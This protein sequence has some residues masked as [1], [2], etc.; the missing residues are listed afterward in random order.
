MQAIAVGAVVAYSLVMT[1]LI[2]SWPTA[3]WATGSAPR[4][5]AIGLDLS[6]HGEAAYTFTRHFPRPPGPMAP[7][8]GQGAPGTGGRGE[9]RADRTRADR[10]R[11]Q[12]R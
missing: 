4:E 12:A 9:V 11:P 10:T 7:V 6:Q 5:E 1:L 8:P 3:C 2:A